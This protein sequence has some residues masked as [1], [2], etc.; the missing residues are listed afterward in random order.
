MPAGRR[1]LVPGVQATSASLGRVGVWAH[2][3]RLSGDVARGLERL[4]YG[5]VW[6][7]GSP[8][9]DLALVDELLAA[10]RTLVVATGIVNIWKDDAGVVA[11]AHRRITA[12]H[13]GRFLLGVGVGHPEA[14]SDYRR[15]FGALVDYLDALDAGGVPRDERVLAALGPKVLRLSAERSAGAH[16][17]LT[18]PDHTRRARAELGPGVLLAPEQK[19]VLDPDVDAARAAGRQ[20]V[21]YYL[22]LRNYV[23]NL[24]RSGFTDDDLAGEG[25][26]RLIDALVGHGTPAVAAAAV[27]AHLDAGADHV[28]VQLVTDG[29]LVDGLGALADTL[30][31]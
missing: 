22:G 20:V 6:I 25:S 8:D 4:G 31:L 1:P 29:D 23:E 12:A 7:G 21:R 27:T 24:R 11:A 26:D 5:T 17:Y 2:H 16:P 9:G 30:A 28:A 18:A 13:P 14:T 19:I 3:D 10:T 15:P